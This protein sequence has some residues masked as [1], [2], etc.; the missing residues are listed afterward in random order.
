MIIDVV[1]FIDGLIIFHVVFIM[2]K[3]FIENNALLKLFVVF[4]EK[5]V[6]YDVGE[7]NALFWVDYEQFLK[8]IFHIGGYL[9]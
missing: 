1:F 3:L 9:L 8:E 2:F 6:L 7:S 5:W 4:E